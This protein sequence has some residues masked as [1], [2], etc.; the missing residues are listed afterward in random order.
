MSLDFALKDF[1]RK[2]EQTYPY[3]FTI[4]LVVALSVFSVYLTNNLKIGSPGTNPEDSVFSGAINLVY[5]QF[6][7][8]IL[9][10]ILILSITLIMIVLISLILSKKKDIAIMKSLGTLPEYLYGFYLLEI[11][12]IFLV[13]F[14]IGT[15]F[16]FV[17][18]GFFY[19]IAPFLNIVL[20]FKID[21]LYIPLFF[22]VCLIGIYI[23][24]GQF[25]R[26]IGIE[27]I[28]KTLSKDL[29]HNYDA[30]K[31]YTIIPR[32]LIS[33]GYNLKM[34]VINTMRQRSRFIRYVIVFSLVLL[35]I[36]TL[37]LGNLVLGNS[38]QNWIR[39]SQGENIVVIGHQDIVNNYSL[40]YKK[41][42]DPEI[43]FS[44][45]S[46]N[47]TN[48]K[49][50]FNESNINKLKNFTQ[51][52]NIEKRLIRF[53]DIRELDGII[54]YEEGGYRMVGEQRTGTYPI[55][56]VN[57]S[58]LIPN[59]EI[60][61]RFFDETDYYYNMCVGDGLAYNFFEYPLTQSMKLESLD[62]IFHVSGV[63]IDSFY[64]G[65]AGY[66]DLDE[67][68]EVLNLPSTTINL[69]LVKYEGDLLNF[70]DELSSFIH[71][72]LGDSFS[73]EALDSIF[74]ENI[75]ALR[76]LNIYPF[77]MI[78][79]VGIIGIYSL[80]NYQKA[81]LMEKIK[82]FKIMRSIGAKKRS[83]KRILFFEGSFILLPSIILSLASGMIIN[84]TFLLDRVSLPP[85][86][87]PFIFITII[88]FIF[89]GIN[90]LTLAPILKKISN[91]SKQFLVL[92]N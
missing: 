13:G 14:L 68:Q 31:R 57:S 7:N 50:L 43:S 65:Y 4:V 72:N 44:K 75:N 91:H 81:G 45:D 74:E 53:C 48:E 2:R 26:R 73:F 49:Y 90:Y 41:F 55:M 11:Y 71:N 42:S 32:W 28:V 77:F 40:M 78:F 34:A 66:V 21:F 23:L 12:I 84:S 18:Y 47:F 6:N 52:I 5:S 76:S 39:K 58:N 79:I 83:I 86:H 30:S 19:Y 24:P 35:T 56:G 70:K 22:I 16:G 9:I 85:V 59:F 82:D 36:F 20:S 67:L 15:I 8:V 1:Y 80:Y 27:K 61:G 89:L 38:S 37:G 29:R 54:Y 17:T 60:E 88:F 51:I 63:V 33:L 10:L 46:L 92:R 69:L 62:K 64:N 87:I 25:L 3:L